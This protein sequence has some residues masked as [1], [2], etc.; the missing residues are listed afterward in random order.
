MNVPR[1]R[2]YFAWPSSFRSSGGFRLSPA[3]GTRKNGA[4]PVVAEPFEGSSGQ[5]QGCPNPVRRRPLPNPRKIGVGICCLNL[6]MAEELSDHRKT[7]AEAE[8]PRR[9][10]TTL[11][12]DR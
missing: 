11:A 7:F 5:G 1:C 6:T 9:V 10:G 3:H 2:L 12:S 4:D 8:S